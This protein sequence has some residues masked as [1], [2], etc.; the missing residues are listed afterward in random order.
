M[1]GW[2]GGTSLVFECLDGEH[3]TP[4]LAIGYKYSSKTTSVFVVSK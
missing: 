2:P 4:L 3:K 1:K